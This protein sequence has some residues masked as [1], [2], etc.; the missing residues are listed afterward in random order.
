MPHHIY[1]YGPV[2]QYW[3]RRHIVVNHPCHAF[4]THEWVVCPAVTSKPI[5][6]EK[7]KNSFTRQYGT[8]CIPVEK[9]QL[10]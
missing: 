7:I 6:I 5:T 1:M 2:G 3:R 8:D 9:N 4:I 10:C